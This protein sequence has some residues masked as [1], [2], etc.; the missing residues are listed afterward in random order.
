MS[1]VPSPIYIRP[2]LYDQH[3]SAIEELL[4]HSSVEYPI[5]VLKLSALDMR[6]VSVSLH[7]PSLP[8]AYICLIINSHPIVAC[9]DVFSLSQRLE[10]PCSICI[11]VS[12]EKLAIVWKQCI[13]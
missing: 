1:P 9:S 8:R 11:L 3:R 13:L 2:V 4:D 5:I 6:V 7:V 10:G 12:G